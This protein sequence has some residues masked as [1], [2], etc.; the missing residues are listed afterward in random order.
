MW[1]RRPWVALLAV[2]VAVVVSGCAAQAPGPIGTSP[3]SQ[4]LTPEQARQ[5]DCSQV[6]SDVVALSVLTSTIGLAESR[7]S[8]AQTEKTLVEMQRTAP[9]ELR[10]VYGRML[11]AIQA[12]G[13]ALPASTP[14]PSAHP[15]PS[16]NTSPSPSAT[17]QSSVAPSPTRS[18]FD[19]HAFDL[20]IDKLRAWIGAHC[21][22]VSAPLGQ[23]TQAGIA[24]PS[25]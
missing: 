6:A 19:S 2:V 21:A 12:F 10:A 24:V 15:T 5:A 17:P 20:D 14:N 7:E 3:T 18:A 9:D 22:D 25:G 23:E 4:S 1:R 13:S 8:L 11:S 16:T